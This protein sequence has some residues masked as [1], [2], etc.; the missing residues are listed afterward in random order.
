VD[1]TQLLVAPPSPPP[2]PPTIPTTPSPGLLTHTQLLGLVQQLGAA[3]PAGML[4]VPAAVELL[5][6]MAAAGGCSAPPP[7]PP[8]FGI[9]GS[10]F[11]NPD[12][13]PPTHTHNPK[14]SPWVGNHTVWCCRLL[15]GG[16]TS[17]CCWC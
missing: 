16:L 10:G 5:M 3:A 17:A 11:V 6:A 7:P 4:R 9:Y 13:P 1:E 14:P 8:G 12:P 2:P 15:G